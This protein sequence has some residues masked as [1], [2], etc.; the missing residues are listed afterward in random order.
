MDKETIKEIRMAIQEKRVDDFKRMASE[1]SDT[2]E[3]VTFFGTFLHD[4]AIF[5]SY[6]IAKYLVDNGIDVNKKA[7][8]RNS[9]ALTSAAYRGY[10]DI[11]KLLYENGCKLYVDTFDENPLFA[12]ICERHLDVVK[13]L[14]EKGI[15]LSPKYTI[16]GKQMDACEYASHYAKT[17]ILSYL[18]EQLGKEPPVEKKKR[19]VVVDS[20]K[21]PEFDYGSFEERLYAKMREVM[22]KYSDRRDDIYAFSIKY[23]PE[24]TSFINIL[25]NSYS[26]LN[27]CAQKGSFSLNDYK[28]S[29][30]DWG[31][32]E[33]I[34]DLSDDL[35]YHYELVE[36][37]CG[38]DEDLYEDMYEEHKKRIIDTCINVMMKIKQSE[39][40]SIYPGLNLN[41]YVREGMSED[42]ELEIFKKL[43]DE[44]AVKEFEKFMGKG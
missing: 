42:E 27:E 32:W 24:F 17:E 35:A 16:G 7:G 10:L 9:T 3:V 29:E 1:N 8:Y 38:E 28:Y 44:Q 20:S 33:K 18:S 25:A 13:Y 15:D 40:Y 22:K 43:N 30:E 23:E 2:L 21:K 34:E 26:Y 41:V 12:A 14:V 19:E 39:E 5:G 6:E 31:I 11:V 37:W 4:A 36:K